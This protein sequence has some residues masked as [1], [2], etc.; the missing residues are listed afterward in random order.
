MKKQLRA[1]PAVE[2]VLQRIGKTEL[3]RPALVTLIRRE[4]ARIRNEK[5]IPDHDEI[6]SQIRAKLSSLQRSRIQPVINGTGV[7][8]HT[9]LGR[10]VLPKA[11][12]DALQFVASQY[13]T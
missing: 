6:M 10:S 12:Q 1:I 5:K 2:K 3:P 9:N 13:N 7:I 11:A 4:L 8:I